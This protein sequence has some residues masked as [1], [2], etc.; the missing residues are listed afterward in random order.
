MFK[1]ARL[2]F[3]F[4]LLLLTVGAVIEATAV[5]VFLIP[6]QIAPGGVS[7]VSVILNHL[8][9]TPVGL[10]VLLGNIPIQL[11]AYR[12]LGGGGV[13]LATVYSVIVFS[14]AVDLLTP[15]IGTE[16]VTDNTLLA[17]LFGG[18]TGGIGGGLIMRAGGTT[19]GTA[20]LA[21]IL[22]HRFG[23][24]LNNAF[25]YTDTLVMLAAGL[26]FGWEAAMLA[27]VS[28]FVSGSA[29]DYVLEGPSVIRTVTIITDHPDAVAETLLQNLHRGVTA[30]H[31]TGMY[32]QQERR[33]LYVVVTR[34]Q[35]GHTRQL[36]LS[37]DPSAFIVVG[38]GHVA[39]GHGFKEVKV[40]KP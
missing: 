28:L 2:A 7:G 9:G 20:T 33:V 35:V 24:P 23:I 38:H 1:H 36:V 15:I 4:T 3:L 26:S 40:V 13:V 29:A 22:Q 25:L 10:V 8:I 11:L 6:A 19:G 17:A 39:Y 5:I 21:R 34:P 37:V 30:W 31:G 27:M 14:L 18:I 32:T 12:T 16:G